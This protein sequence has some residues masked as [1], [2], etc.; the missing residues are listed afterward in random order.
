MELEQN[1]LIFLVSICIGSLLAFPVSRLFVNDLFKLLGTD[2]LIMY[3][4]VPPMMTPK[5]SKISLMI[6]DNRCQ[7]ERK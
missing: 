1:F 7:G 6:N 3:A 2:K 4:M 5:R